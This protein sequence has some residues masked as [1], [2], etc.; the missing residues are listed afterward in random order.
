MNITINFDDETIISKL[1][2]VLEELSGVSVKETKCKDDK[3][4]NLKK[5]TE[6]FCKYEKWDKVNAIED[7][8]DYDDVKE[9]EFTMSYG[10]EPEKVF[11]AGFEIDEPRACDY[12]DREDFLH[13]HYLYDRFVEAGEACV[14]AGLERKGDG[15]IIK[16]CAIKKDVD[17]IPPINIE[18]IGETQWECE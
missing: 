1:V 11:G 15:E 3:E 6:K 4:F 16:C 17:D 13:D 10:T 14:E 5:D 7:F 2:K 8:D 18:L 12:E 9:V